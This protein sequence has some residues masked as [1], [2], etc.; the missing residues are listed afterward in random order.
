MKKDDNSGDG[1]NA[2]LRVYF[3]VGHSYFFEIWLNSPNDYGQ[4]TYRLD[5]ISSQYS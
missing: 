5:F 2:S 3:L 1:F 4:L